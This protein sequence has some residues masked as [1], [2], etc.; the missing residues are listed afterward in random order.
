MGFDQFLAGQVASLS[1]RFFIYFI[2]IMLTNKTKLTIISYN[3]VTKL[4]TYLYKICQQYV[5][6]HLTQ[7]YNYL[8]Q[9]RRGKNK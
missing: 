6:R 3:S 7:V 1:S 2:F 5:Q 4:Q 9:K 8:K